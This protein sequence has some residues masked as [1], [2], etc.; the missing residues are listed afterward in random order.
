VFSPDASYGLVQV[1]RN[2]GRMPVVGLRY[3]AAVTG[4]WKIFEVVEFERLDQ[5]AAQAESLSPTAIV[6]DRDQVR[7]SIYLA[8]TAFVR[9]HT[10]AADPTDLLAE[11]KKVIGPTQDGDV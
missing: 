5:L 8:H 3:V 9:I 6:I 2:A 11:I 7:R 4:P 1:I 10:E